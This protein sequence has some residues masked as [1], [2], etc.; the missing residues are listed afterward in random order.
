V[1]CSLDKG[2]G[3]REDAT[4]DWDWGIGDQIWALTGLN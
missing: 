3:Q 2:A 1:R 4:A